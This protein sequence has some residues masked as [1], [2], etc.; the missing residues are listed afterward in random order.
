MTTKTS[1]L[2]SISE[3]TNSAPASDSTT[4]SAIE[5]T[6]GS[7]TL[8]TVTTSESTTTDT[9]TSASD[10]SITDSSTTDLV[11]TETSTT[12]TAT[13]GTSTTE[14]FTSIDATATTTTSS[15]VGTST[16]SAA[17]PDST[18]F[19]IQVTTGRA[20][21][22]DYV[23][24]L[25][26]GQLTFL[27]QPGIIGQP[28]RV[29]DMTVTANGALLLDG[30]APM[31]AYYEPYKSYG[32]L[33][34]CTTEQ[35]EQYE[36]LT[37]RLSTMGELTCS[38]PAKLCVYQGNG[39]VCLTNGVYTTWYTGPRNDNIVYTFNLGPENSNNADLESMTFVTVPA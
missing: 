4:E 24:D 32:S 33:A 27:V 29:R 19:H 6:S 30:V 14:T 11:S 13:A 39:I 3:T 26:R 18:P 22:F 38:I 25:Q 8:L 1:E 15:T 35:N 12:A 28:Y 23:S 9:T 36:P 37:C 21:G 31:C 17:A 16:T 2:S 5:S 10:V 7:T 34:I 20:T